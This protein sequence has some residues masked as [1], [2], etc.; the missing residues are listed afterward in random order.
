MIR[1]NLTT[2]LAAVIIVG[3]TAGTSGPSMAATQTDAQQETSAQ[4]SAFDP[5]PT[6]QE[7]SA[8]ALV[9]V[10]GDDEDIDGETLARINDFLSALTPRTG[11]I[12]IRSANATLDVPTTHYFLDGPD[13]RRVLEEAWGNPPA[14]N[15]L[16]MIFPAGLTPFD[17]AVWGATVNYTADGYVSDE[18]ASKIN[19]DK[20]LGDLQRSTREANDW[21][22]EN[23]YET[24]DLVGWAEPP[25]YNA[26]THKLYWAKELAFGNTDANTLNYDIRVLGRRGVLELQFVAGMN[27]LAEIRDTAPAVLQMANFNS[28]AT[29]AEYQPGVDKKAAYG[30]A[31]LVGGAA[32]AKKL[33]LFG[34]VLAFGKKFIVLILAGLAGLAGAARRMFGGGGNKDVS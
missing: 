24:I 15:T 14:E 12:P 33:G 17:D 11:S 10:P 5:A 23:G 20:L 32:L 21:R 25:S 19:Y 31:G 2:T 4:E 8:S 18:E 22:T 16:G 27:Q 30:I 26:Q 13:A 7:A 3:S 28:G 1:L 34:L 29:Y 9:F 6:P